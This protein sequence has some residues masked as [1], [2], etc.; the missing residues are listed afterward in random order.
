[1][2]SRGGVS[3]GV[4]VTIAVLGVIALGSSVLAFIFLA[5]M[6]GA[7]KEARDL[8][9]S[10]ADYVTDTER[11]NDNV[12]LLLGEAKKG[13]KSLAGYLQAQFREVAD[14]V[15]GSSADTP[16]SLN[17]K[18]AAEVG[19]SGN[20]I[21]ALQD[22]RGKLAASQAALAQAETAR[23][24]AVDNL[25][26]AQDRVKAMEDAH[27]ATVAAL[28]ADVGTYKSQ[29]DS[30]TTGMNTRS[31]EAAAAVEKI[32]RDANDEISRLNDQIARLNEEM[33]VSQNKI[34]SLQKERSAETLRPADEAA[35]VDG[36]VVA[37]ADADGSV[38][39]NRG[40]NQ[41]IV[42]GMTFAVYANASDIKP[43]A[44]GDYPRG[45]AQ[46]E[47]TRVDDN[48]STARI[49]RSTRG[50]PVGRGDVIANALYDPNKKYGFLVYGNFDTNGDGRATPEE[51]TEIKAIITG[52]GGKIVDSLSGDV[53]FIVLGFR[54]ALPPPPPSD[55]PVP[56][57]QEF[58]RQRNI[59]REYDRLLEQ[60]ANTSIPVLNQNRL[61]TLMGR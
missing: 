7:Q 40:R 8:K 16:E 41:R 44:N 57:V 56:V 49:V 12:R 55:A 14:K 46:I 36:Q 59:A 19:D 42:L 34:K 10:T 33:L 31:Q 37:V 32:K 13:G 11:N 24:A 38:Y 6:Q 52:W 17:K 1:M 2:A 15:T 3:T 47:V 25:K 35:L 5:K 28:Q 4:G 27:A 61:E 54:P 26:S 23:Q 39:I 50:N 58:I 43:N 9:A 18:V 48:T 30:F 60:A 20:L 29:I 22:A 45:K 53:D 21:R 51:A